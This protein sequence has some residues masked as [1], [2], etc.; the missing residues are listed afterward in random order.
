M[1]RTLASLVV[2]VI[3]ASPAFGC[4]TCKEGLVG[5]NAGNLV[6]GYEWSIIFMMSAPFLILAGIGG[7]FYYEIR[8]AR[9][10]L[11]RQQLPAT[12]QPVSQMS[13]AHAMRDR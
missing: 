6:R 1:R 8:R 4:P 7:Y 2:L 9:W 3:I 13:S 11:A 10:E 12:G 5:A